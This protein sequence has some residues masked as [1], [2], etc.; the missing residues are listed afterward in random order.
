[1]SGFK[2]EALYSIALTAFATLIVIVSSVLFARLASVEELGKFVFFQSIVFLALIPIQLGLPDLIV[3]EVATYSAADNPNKPVSLVVTWAFRVAFY[4]G[5]SMTLMILGLLFIFGRIGQDS[6][7]LVALLP[8]LLIAP[9]I[10]IATAAVRAHGYPLIGQVPDKILRPIGAII[11]VVSTHFLINTDGLSAQHLAVGTT[12]GFMVALVTSAL[13]FR[14]IFPHA[15][16][17]QKR[18][19]RGSFNLGVAISLGAITAFHT[20]GVQI[21]FIVLGLFVSETQVGIYRV[22]TAVASLGG[23]A[24]LA[25]NLVA[26]PRISASR[27]QSL[28]R[29]EIGAIAR[30]TA[31][32]GVIL[33]LGFAM[34]ITVSG[35]DLLVGFFGRQYMDSFSPLQILVFG[36]VVSSIFGPVAL[37]LSMTGHERMVLRVMVAAFAVKLFLILFLVRPL[38]ADGVAISTVANLLIWNIVL[39]IVAKKRLRLDTSI[40]GYLALRSNQHLPKT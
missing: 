14:S 13:L 30:W 10:N 31:L 18:T 28:G 2:S 12:L 34:I 36:Q 1:M 23:S 4:A 39:W 38:G 16:K 25:I 22:A 33:S 3:R 7:A 35:P 40:F 15:K 9:R 32:I 29:I 20:V 26:A 6:L 17:Y 5:I 21:D 24:L 19:K 8:I 27:S 37:T 11:V